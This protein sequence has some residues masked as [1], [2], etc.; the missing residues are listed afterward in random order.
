MAEPTAGNIIKALDAEVVIGGDLDRRVQNC[1]VSD[2]LSDVLAKSSEGDLW[3]TQHTHSNIVAVASVK[4]LAAI[5]I[6]GE[7]TLSDETLEKAR[8]E[9]VTIAR[10]RMSAFEAAG[11]VYNLMKAGGGA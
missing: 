6:V 4:G 1:Y 11:K 5:L 9:G 2:L 8:A 10:A 3:I 7:N